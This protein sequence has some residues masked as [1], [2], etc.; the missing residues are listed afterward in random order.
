MDS[1]VG[2]RVLLRS[3]TKASVSVSCLFATLFSAG[4]VAGAERTVKKE[5]AKARTEKKEVF[6]LTE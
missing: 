3:V 2:A 6:M 5:L 4:A 1:I